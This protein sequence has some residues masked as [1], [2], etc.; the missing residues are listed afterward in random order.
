M[1]GF[2]KR[3][4]VMA[5]LAAALTAPAAAQTTQPARPVTVT[6]DARRS[7]GPLPPAWRFFGADEPNY[8]TMKDGR[9]LLVQLGDLKRGEI[10]FRAHN[11]L[12][13]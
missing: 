2:S 5:A 12:R 7:L 10:F 9:K 1:T 13:V 11:L 4:I 8:A 6:V 3:A